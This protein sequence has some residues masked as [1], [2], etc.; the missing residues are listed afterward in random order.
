VLH[1][2]FP[3]VPGMV[4]ERDTEMNTGLAAQA[5]AQFAELD[6]TVTDLLTPRVKRSLLQE[7][8]ECKRKLAQAL[9]GIEGLDVP[10]DDRRVKLHSVAGAND[11]LCPVIC[12]SSI[13]PGS[14]ISRCLPLRRAI[15]QGRA[16]LSHARISR[17]I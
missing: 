1:I 10:R 8:G 11:I 9:A 16:N 3:P 5:I 4:S 13:K 6:G 7:L 2:L 12:R 14:S 15:R 17:A